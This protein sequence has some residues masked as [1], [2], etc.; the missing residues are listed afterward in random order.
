MRRVKVLFGCLFEEQ[1]VFLACLGDFTE[2]SSFDFL[3]DPSWDL[4]S[5]PVVFSNLRCLGQLQPS[6]FAKDSLRRR[7]P[8]LL[9]HFVFLLERGK[10]PSLEFSLEGYSR[11]IL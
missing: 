6:F 4:T 10:H 1:E 5:K 7:G 8:L 2:T 3:V 11:G 9:K